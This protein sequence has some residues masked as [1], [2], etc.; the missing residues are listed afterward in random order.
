MKQRLTAAGLFL[1]CLVRAAM[2][3]DVPPPLALRVDESRGHDVAVRAADGGAVEVRTTGRDVYVFLKP[4][5]AGTKVELARLPESARDVVG[6]T[7][8]PA[9]LRLNAPR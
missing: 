3:A 5:E 4:A 8:R 9:E 6:A 7:T 1:L 2:A